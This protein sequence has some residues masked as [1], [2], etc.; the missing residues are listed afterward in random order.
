MLQVCKCASTNSNRV[1]FFSDFDGDNQ[2]SL[3]DLIETVQRLT[4]T[5]ERGQAR[6]DPQHAQDV[7]R[8]VGMHSCA[9]STRLQ[10]MESGYD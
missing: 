6:I 7:A 2:I 8:M 10:R 9:S 4:G 1:I 5:N 3:N